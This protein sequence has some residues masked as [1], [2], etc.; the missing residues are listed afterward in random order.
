[1][2]CFIVAVS[3]IQFDKKI[4]VPHCNVNSVFYIK[5]DFQISMIYDLAIF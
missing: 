1:M 2:S 3:K 5:H 4:M